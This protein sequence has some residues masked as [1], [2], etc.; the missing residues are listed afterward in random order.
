MIVMIMNTVVTAVH[1]NTGFFAICLMPYVFGVCLFFLWSDPD[2]HMKVPGARFYT[3]FAWL[4][5]CNNELQ[6]LKYT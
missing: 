3:L 5:V 2:C 4:E 6:M 1:L